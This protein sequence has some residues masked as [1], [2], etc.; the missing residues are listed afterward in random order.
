MNDVAYLIDT[1]PRFCPA[2]GKATGWGEGDYLA[3]QDFY[4]GCSQSCDCG[5]QYQY[6]TREQ[7]IDA[8]THHPKGDLYRYLLRQQR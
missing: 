8:A 3:R 5:V 7:M 1:L 6:L 2:C 4:A